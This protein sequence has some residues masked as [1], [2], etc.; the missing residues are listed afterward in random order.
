[1][2]KIIFGFYSIFIMISLSKY[3]H[4]SAKLKSVNLGGFDLDLIS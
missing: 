2:L 4:F 1:M 3:C